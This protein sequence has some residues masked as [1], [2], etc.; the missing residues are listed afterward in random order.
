M[1]Q[2]STEDARGERAQVRYQVKEPVSNANLL[3]QRVL[4]P[5]SDAIIL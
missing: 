4:L 2:I 3:A 1:Q 5:S